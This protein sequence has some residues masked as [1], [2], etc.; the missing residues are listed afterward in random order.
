MPLTTALAKSIN[1]IPVIMSLEIGRKIGRITHDV[2]AAKFGR[3]KIIETARAMGLTTPLT[4]TVSLP[5]GGRADRQRDRIGERRRQPHAAG[6][7]DDLGPAGLAAF[8]SCVI[9]PLADLERH[10]SPG[11]C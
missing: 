11:W 5:I 7:L 2:N 1:T 8:A 10:A 4:D 9:R 3:A 6:G